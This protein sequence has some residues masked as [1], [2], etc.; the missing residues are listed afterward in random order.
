VLLHP[1]AEL[2]DFVIIS[3]ILTKPILTTSTIYKMKQDYNIRA[4]EFKDAEPIFQLI[5]SF[6]DELLPRPISDIVQ[7]IDRFL[8]CETGGEVA[9]TISW[10]ILPEI[11]SPRQ[12]SVEIKSL[13]VK[14]E[15]QGRQVGKELVQNAIQRI[16]ELHPIQII[17]LTFQPEFFARLGF[18]KIPKA[19]LMHKIYAG[20]INCT[21]YDSPFTCPETAVGMEL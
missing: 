19:K 10:H 5:K 14:K 20:C 11:G 7:N 3:A 6:P 13:A 8:V 16:S 18:R 4:A 12:P 15:H 2:P 1:H 21:K 9:G 17:A